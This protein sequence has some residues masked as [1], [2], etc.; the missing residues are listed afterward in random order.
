MNN[1]MLKN[2]L[3]SFVIVFS[4]S[5][6]KYEGTL[7]EILTNEIK[8]SGRPIANQNDKFESILVL[9]R[10]SIEAIKFDN[11]LESKELKQ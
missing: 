9:K 5:G 6:H 2:L 11:I 1:E 8:I 3:N 7:K 10:D 4:K